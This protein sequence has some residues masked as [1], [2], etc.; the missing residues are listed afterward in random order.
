MKDFIIGILLVASIVGITSAYKN[1]TQLESLQH[2]Y[3]ELMQDYNA[4]NK[5]TMIQ[6][7]G[8]ER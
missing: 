7:L 1:Y 6:F 4:I 2:E 3:N 8:K 5:Q